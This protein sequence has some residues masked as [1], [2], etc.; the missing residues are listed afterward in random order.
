MRPVQVA[1]SAA[2]IVGNWDQ[3]GSCGEVAGTRGL[4]RCAANT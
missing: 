2:G 1:G 4:S 3:P